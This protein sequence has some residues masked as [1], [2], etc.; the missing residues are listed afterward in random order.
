MWFTHETEQQQILQTNIAVSYNINWT[1]EIVP[2]AVCSLQLLQ[3]D[4]QLQPHW[5]Q[6]LERP[7]NENN[8]PIN[9]QGASSPF[10]QEITI[11]HYAPKNYRRKQ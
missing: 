6:I 11:A 8:N 9:K 1:K 2:K 10:Q 4:L 5:T 7:T 3:M